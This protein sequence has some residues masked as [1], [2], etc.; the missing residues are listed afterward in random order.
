MSSIQSEWHL[1]PES[2][3]FVLIGSALLAIGCLR[4]RRVRQRLLNHSI[5]S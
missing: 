4:H 1:V 5:D 2:S 3:T